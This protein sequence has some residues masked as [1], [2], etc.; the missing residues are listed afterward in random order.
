MD[1]AITCSDRATS[2]ANIFFFPFSIIKLTVPICEASLND[3]V[4]LPEP[5]LNGYIFVP[6]NN[7]ANTR[8]VG[9]GLFY[10]NS[11]LVVVRNY[12]SFD[13][14]IVVELK[15]RKKKYFLLFCI[16]ALPLITTLVIFKPF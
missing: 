4:E 5:L 11:L 9:V 1:Y 8:H 10:K 7:P 14:F 3:Y 16:E 15:F 13:E 2:I 6:A 12:L